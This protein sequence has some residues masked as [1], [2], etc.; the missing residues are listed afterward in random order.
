[1]PIAR[2]DDFFAEMLKTDDHMRGIKSRLL[3]QQSKIKSFEDK[4]TRSENKKFHKALRDH[5]MRAKHAEK[6]ENMKNIEQLKK[7]VQEK[8]SRGDDMADSEFDSIM[9]TGKGVVGGKK[10]VLQQV[11]NSQKDKSQ[12]KKDNLGFK[13]RGG[14][15][16]SNPHIKGKNS[17]KGNGFKGKGGKGG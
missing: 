2:P 3:S 11:R 13:A 7:R 5:K 10:K 14:G 12:Q 17:K 6:R 15:V 8:G 16:G 4:K 9:K 1:M